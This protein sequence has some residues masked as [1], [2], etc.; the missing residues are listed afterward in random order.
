MN[1][2]DFHRMNEILRPVAPPQVLEGVYSDDQHARML[3]VIKRNGPWRTITADH[4]DTVEELMATS[5][6]GVPDDF[7]LTL[8]D[9]ATGHFRGMFGENSVPYYPELEDCLGKL[10][11]WA[12]PESHG[13]LCCVDASS[14]LQRLQR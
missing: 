13:R 4:F 12:C 1:Q 8:D 5:N 7:N 3:D 6:G 2:D 10:P 11:G 14:P 9:M